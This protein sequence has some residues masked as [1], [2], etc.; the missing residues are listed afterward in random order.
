MLLQDSGEL[1]VFR[2]FVTSTNPLY[3]NCFTFNTGWRGNVYKQTHSGPF[4][5]GCRVGFP[6]RVGRGR[7]GVG[8]VSGPGQGRSGRGFWAGA[9]AEWA[10]FL[11]G[12]RDG[13]GGVYGRGQRR[14]GRGFW[15]GA[16]LEWAGFLGGAVRDRGRVR[17]GRNG[18]GSSNKHCLSHLALIAL[19]CC[20]ADCDK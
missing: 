1:S 12:G 18:K 11:G 13:V 4:Y 2:T 20:D 6:G 19:L 3:G 5:G 8:G 14:S 9:G 15:A 7:G 17:G 10:G 16:G